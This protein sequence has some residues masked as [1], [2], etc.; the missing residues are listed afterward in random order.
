MSFEKPRILTESELNTIRGKALVGH[1]TPSEL[2]LA[3]GH[4]DLV[5]IELQKLRSC[6]PDKIFILGAYGED[7]SADEPDQDIEYD[8]VDLKALLG[9]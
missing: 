2:M 3:F 6:F 8:E 4:F 9:D 1:A 7:W 5:L